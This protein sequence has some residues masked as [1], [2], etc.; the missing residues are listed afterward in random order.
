MTV[1]RKRAVQVVEAEAGGGAEFILCRVL[2]KH[3]TGNAQ[4]GEHAGTRSHN[5]RSEGFMRWGMVTKKGCKCTRRVSL[6]PEQQCVK[7]R[8]THREWR[9]RGPLR[10]AEPRYTVGIMDLCPVPQC[11]R[12]GP[13]LGLKRI[14]Y[15]RQRVGQVVL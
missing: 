8:G 15:G 3:G 4:A 9:T 14:L 5:A 2:R 7:P 11:T 13:Y 12:R 10:G 6:C 1:W